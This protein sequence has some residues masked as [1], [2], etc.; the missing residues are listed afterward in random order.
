MMT[1]RWKITG[2][3]STAV[4]VLMIPVS[5][6][7]HKTSDVTHKE[8]AQF[9][10]GKECISCHKREYDLWKSSK[11]DNAM[12]FATDSTV[13]GDFNNAESEANGVKHKFYKRDGKFFVYTKGEGGSMTEYEVAYTFGVKPLQQ[14]LIP[15]RKGKF[16]CLPIAWDTERKKW[17]DMSA[18]VYRPE[19]LKPHSWFYWTNQ[20]QNWNGMCAECHSTNLQKNYNIETDSFSTTWSDIDVNCESCHGPGSNHL[21]WAKLGEGSRVFDGDKG[22]VIKTSGTTS[23]QYIE[24]CAPCHSRRN[25]FGPDNHTESEFLNKYRPENIIPPLYHA[26]GQILDEVFE[27]ASFTQSKMYMHDVKC[28]DCHDSH[29]L[30]FKFEG[31]ALCTQCHKAEEFDTYRHHFHKYKNESGNPVKNKAGESVPVGEGAL[32]VNCHMPGKYYM[33][34]HFRRDHSLRVPRPDISVKY[35]TPNAC[36]ECHA[37]KS[38]QW[39][40]DYV[41]KYF[42]ESKK[43]TYESALIEGSLR[44]AGADTALIRIARS[45]L[46]PEMIRAAA[47]YY[48]TA[49]T[50]NPDALA[51]IQEMLISPEPLLR[52]RAI[53]AYNSSNPELIVRNISPLLNDPVKMVRI[54][55]AS[56][57][58]GISKESFTSVQLELRAKALDEY[59]ASI[60]YTADFPTGKYNLGNFY[61]DKGDYPK[62]VVFYN[63]AIR[64]D[65]MFYPAKSNLAMLYYNTGS[66]ENAEK[67]FLN[68]IQ[69]HPE[70]SDGYYYLGLLYAEQKRYKESA[71]ALENGLLKNPANAKIYYNLGIIYQYLGNNSKSE[72]YLLK[73]Y[74]VFQYDFKVLY[75]LVDFYIKKRDYQKARKYADEIKQKHPDN[76]DGIKILNYLNQITGNTN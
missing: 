42:G 8:K 62:A 59:F 33:G 3:I 71:E 34:I 4:I 72:L 60:L 41:K 32:C 7:L 23:K 44:K 38:N 11:H 68:L 36:N 16:Q 26:D 37:D 14:Y 65:S 20:S 70:Y 19:E 9:T 12:D 13:L 1:D 50:G 58:S 43:Y 63:N 30:K 2:I 56:K 29:S 40:E 25:S 73:G 10:G 46:Y 21:D 39:S 27:F 54:S 52:E 51:V 48:L 31:N 74:S 18:M 66:P 57:L 64:M 53:D 55:A 28:R 47:V 35:N 69:N 15:F 6:V 49:Y 24:S 17:F 67:L 61:A 5:L 22:L 75:A 45:N 76:Q